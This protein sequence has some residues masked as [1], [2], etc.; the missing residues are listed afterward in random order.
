MLTNQSS[1]SRDK[2]ID[3][4]LAENSK[5][6]D[7][8]IADSTKAVKDNDQKIKH[9]QDTLNRY[10][11]VSPTDSSRSSGITPPETSNSPNES[12]IINES[13]T[14]EETVNNALKGW[15]PPETNEDIENKN[16]RLSNKS[17]LRNISNTVAGIDKREN[18]FWNKEAAKEAWNEKNDKGFSAPILGRITSALVIGLGKSKLFASPLGSFIKFMF[19]PAGILLMYT[20]GKLLKKYVWDPYIGPV[21][22]YLK[23]KIVPIVEETLIYFRGTVIPYL[24]DKVLPFFKSLFPSYEEIKKS[25]YDIIDV[26]KNP[27]SLFEKIGSILNLADTILA[28][29]TNLIK[30]VYVKILGSFAKIT[31]KLGMKDTTIDIL[32]KQSEMIDSMH[33]E[34]KEVS[35]KTLNTSE[36][37]KKYSAVIDMNAALELNKRIKAGLKLSKDE[38]TISKSESY[39]SMWGEASKPTSE[40]NKESFDAFLKAE[41][42]K[43]M[44]LDI[45]TG[46]YKKSGIKSDEEMVNKARISYESQGIS[47]AKKVLDE[48]SKK[49]FTNEA[50]ATKYMQQLLTN[51]EGLSKSADAQNMVLKQLVKMLTE[52]GLRSEKTQE[53]L[54]RLSIKAFETKNSTNI[55]VNNAATSIRNERTMVSSP[56]MPIY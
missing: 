51:N 45:N 30:D 34:F 32:Q 54:N 6:L 39:V 55:M 20:I 26:F 24:T 50:E 52:Q 43:T 3:V 53:E 38:A 48:L 14:I 17:F 44:Q 33:G 21:T 4:I 7:K 25:I 37:G 13:T 23:T 40:V 47:S 10:I 31:D 1:L 2:S 56:M 22:L 35:R 12:T 18:F 41:R 28:P 42:D 46:R 15:V 16:D 36:L 49:K 29:I 11:T 9:I 5:K 27:S 19:S 8:F